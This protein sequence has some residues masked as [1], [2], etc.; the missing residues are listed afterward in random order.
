MLGGICIRA[1]RDR[2]YA[3]LGVNIFRTPIHSNQLEFS[4]FFYAARCCAV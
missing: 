3:W 2:Y 1:L 4:G